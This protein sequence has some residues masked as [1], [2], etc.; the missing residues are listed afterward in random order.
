MSLKRLL[1]IFKLKE[2]E[3]MSDEIFFIYL[4][5]GC[6]DELPDDVK[7]RR[8]EKILKYSLQSSEY[9]YYSLRYSELFPEDMIRKIELKCCEDPKYRKRIR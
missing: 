2:K 8:Y 9:S 1:Y 3:R 4:L 6:F 7:E 5:R